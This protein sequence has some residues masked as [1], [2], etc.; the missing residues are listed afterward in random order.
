VNNRN[1]II[2]VVGFALATLSVVPAQAQRVFVSAMGSDGNPC[3]FASPCRTLQQAHDT[4]AAGGEIDVLDP[5]GYGTLAISKSISIQ[6]H[7]WAEVTTTNVGLAA[8]QINVGA[9]DTINLRGVIVEGFGTGQD[10]ITFASGGSLNI[11]DCVIR[12]FTN[13]GISFLPS[14]GSLSLFVSDTLVSDIPNVG[15]GVA[16]NAGSPTM[17]VV[18]NRVQVENGKY[19]ISMSV[20]PGATANVSIVESVV[21]NQSFRGI[22][23]GSSGGAIIAMVRN[24]TVSNNGTGIVAAESGVVVLVAHS[25]ITGNGTGL[26]VF[27]GAT[28]SSYGDNNVD[29][30]TTDGAPTN[31]ILTK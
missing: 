14:S 21:A 15:I 25:S 7:G 2:A 12:H 8:I 9:T 31:T 23:A 16:N 26:A 22:D 24:S 5:A 30:N 13:V 29:G 6:G 18:L 11:Q 20:F 4:V 28:L 3:S 10:G 17:T 27:G 19:G 1:T